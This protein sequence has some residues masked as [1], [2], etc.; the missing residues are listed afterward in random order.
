[1]TLSL[2]VVAPS[3]KSWIHHW[4][5]KYIQ[6]KFQCLQPFKYRCVDLLRKVWEP[7]IIKHLN[8]NSTTTTTFG[9]G[10]S[11]GRQRI[12]V[13]RNIRKLK[14]KTEIDLNLKGTRA[15]LNVKTRRHFSGMP[16]TCM[17]TNRST[18]WRILNM[19]VDCEEGVFPS[20]VRSKLN[21]FEH[22][23]EREGGRALYRRSP[24]WT[25][26]QT[27]TT[28]S[29]TFPQLRWWAETLKWNRNKGPKTLTSKKTQS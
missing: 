8:Y 23:L 4:K 25:E 20:M 15:K 28:E 14:T 27:D 17:P 13:K 7:D 3:G 9:F 1:M 19:S 11:L 2:G 29:I 24:L 16:T 6:N 21:K 5:C 12:R 18:Q 10:L 22:V 26:W